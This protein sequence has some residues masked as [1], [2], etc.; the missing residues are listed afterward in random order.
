MIRPV[1][2]DA[3]TPRNPRGLHAGVLRCRGCVQGDGGAIRD[4]SPDGQDQG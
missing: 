1:T 3:P 4:T 2:T